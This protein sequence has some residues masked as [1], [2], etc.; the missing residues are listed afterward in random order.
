[1]REC[2]SIVNLRNTTDD[3]VAG[4]VGMF[5][6]VWTLTKSDTRVCSGIKGLE[7]PFKYQLLVQAT[8]RHLA[9]ELWL[10]NWPSACKTALAEFVVR[11]CHLMYDLDESQLTK[12]NCF[13]LQYTNYR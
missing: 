7:I 1:M 12:I 8:L 13:W 2:Y 11:G 5:I 10:G 6:A 3:S 9:L 4:K